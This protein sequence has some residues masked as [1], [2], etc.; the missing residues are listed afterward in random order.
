MPRKVLMPSMIMLRVMGIKKLSMR[1]MV[2][3]I[4]V[5]ECFLKYT[6]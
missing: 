4:S 1:K 5:A 2:K 6:R 3:K